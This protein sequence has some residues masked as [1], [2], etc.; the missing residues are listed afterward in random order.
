[1]KPRV[2][3]GATKTDNDD[4]DDHHHHHQIQTKKKVEQ[5]KFCFL[6]KT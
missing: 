3:H 5:M 2:P 4:D 1:V 6:Y